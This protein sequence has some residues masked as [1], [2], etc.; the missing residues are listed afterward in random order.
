[1]S[2]KPIGKL[3]RS[4][5]PIDTQIDWKNVIVVFLMPPL[6]YLV[7]YLTGGIQYSY[8]HLMYIAII[9]AG[10]TLGPQMGVI[11]G[12]YGGILLGPL[13]PIDITIGTK[14]AFANWFLRL[15]IFVIVGAISGY[16][17]SRLKKSIKTISTLFSHN[18]DT[19]IPN[20]NY[21]RDIN[22]NS[23]TS[24]EYIIMTIN[25]NNYDQIV[26]LLG[27]EVYH[28]ILKKIYMYL[29]R[30]LPQDTI[31]IQGDNNKLWLGKPYDELYSD[32]YRV[33]NILK[34][35]LDIDEI[36]FYTEFSLGVNFAS[37]SEVLNPDTY[38]KSDLAARQAQKQNL[39]YIIFHKINLQMYNG[40]DLLG[41]FIEA[42]SENQTYLAY[43]P[44]IEVQTN[45][46]VGLE[47]LIRWQHPARGLIM[48]NDF[49]PLIAETQ[50]IHQLTT[51]VLK[52]V[53]MKIKEFKREKIDI[54]ISINVSVKN[55]LNEEFYNQVMKIVMMEK[56]DPKQIEFEITESELMVNPEDA[57][58][59]LQKFREVGFQI[60]LDDFGKGH[61]SLAYLSQLPI[62]I[63]KIDRHFINKLTREV[64]NRFI[65]KSTIDLAHKLRCKTLAEGIE[66]RETLEIIKKLNCD[67]AQGYYFARPIND[68]AIISWVKD[69]I[70]GE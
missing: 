68:N 32:I 64:A 12:I 40:F 67:Y 55:L 5:R 70:Q 48:P 15:I 21:L 9:L 60:S 56:V 53:I 28:Q 2:K 38:K 66:D 59:M 36:T 45:K 27:I 50:L 65:I 10:T 23:L 39:E 8:S 30:D 3:I 42:L 57:I 46:L 1:M 61:S 17:S 7:V 49:I 47:A 33:L 31:I 16:T 62:N 58:R 25:I 63:V 34:Q 52:K 41:V 69:K 24:D 19:L 22:I 29:R 44:K 54:H 26:D 11:I 14:Q 37:K 4:L 43:Q 13:M 18:L 20:V 6:V 51:W 35:P